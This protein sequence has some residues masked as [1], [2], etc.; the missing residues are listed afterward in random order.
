M[1][2]HLDETQ[3]R[4]CGRRSMEGHQRGWRGGKEEQVVRGEIGELN[5]TQIVW[6]LGFYS[7]A[8]QE[9]MEGFELERNM[10]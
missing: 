7:Q 1:T 5:R 2:D 3:S 6:E 10:L 9:A 4:S 8:G